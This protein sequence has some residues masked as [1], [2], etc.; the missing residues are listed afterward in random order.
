MSKDHCNKVIKN[1]EKAIYHLALTI[2]SIRN[3]QK[4]LPY[5]KDDITNSQIRDASIRLIKR[6][7]KFKNR[8]IEVNKRDNPT[9]RG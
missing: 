9:I 5:A 2:T 8:I 3:N 1:C 4:I 6:I 7:Y